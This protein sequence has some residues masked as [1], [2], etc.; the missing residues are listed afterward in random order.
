MITNDYIAFHAKGSDPATAFL[1]MEW[2]KERG[3][4]FTLDWVKQALRYIRRYERVSPIYLPL[5]LTHTDFY[6]SM[7]TIRD[8]SR[9]FPG[10]AT[11]RGEDEE[12]QG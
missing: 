11:P 12:R 3:E 7:R 9:R 2:N 5:P 10:S 6:L 1:Y 4:P 8:S